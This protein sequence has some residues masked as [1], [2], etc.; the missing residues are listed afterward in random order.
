MKQASVEEVI[1]AA[2]SS[3]AALLKQSGVLGVGHGWKVTAGKRTSQY[4]LVVYVAE[5][6]PLA[7]LPRAQRIPKRIGGVPADIV[8]AGK[9]K[10]RHVDER[11]HRFIDYVKAHKEL[12]K[13]RPAKPPP[14]TAHDRDIG[15]VAVIEDDPN[16]SFIIRKRRDVDWVG[17]YKKFLMTHED[18][19]DFV[20]FW[21]DFEVNCECGAFYCGLVNPTKGINWSACVAGGRAGWNSKRLLGFMYFIRE[22]DA[23]LLQETGHHWMAYTGFKYKPTDNRVSYEICLDSQPG[24][25]NS[26]FDDD[27][28]PMDYDESELRL[29]SGVSVDWVDNGDGTFTPRRV[30]Q[31]QY[32]FSNLDLYLMG[33]MPPDQVGDFFFI[34]NPRRVGRKIRGT[35]VTLNV[36]NIIWANDKR[37]PSVAQSPKSFTNAFILLTKDASQTTARAQEI[38]AVRQRYTTAFAEATGNR[39]QIV[40]TL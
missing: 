6:R 22:D 25:W 35:R 39:A 9:A 10:D 26:Y 38:D 30:G 14:S 17:A 3:R 16:H 31:G 29:P 13:A 15:N 34:E 11:E 28:S 8:V 1:S 23:A 4:A 33:L 19:Y 36:N 24:H 2:Q 32:R 21:S 37:R 5:K 40:T 18:K 12:A 7:Q 20:T 27:A